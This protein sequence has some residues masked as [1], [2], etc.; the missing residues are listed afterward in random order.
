MWHFFNLEKET[1][2]ANYHRRSNVEPTY[3]AL[4]RKLG[5]A[6]RAKN[7]QAQMNEVLVKC[8]LFNLTVLGHEIQELGIDPKFWQ[9][10]GQE[11]AE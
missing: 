3:S 2:L 4:K 10:G 7:E 11:A 8:L 9:P 6:V 5:F 1:W